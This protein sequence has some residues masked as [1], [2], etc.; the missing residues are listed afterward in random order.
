MQALE[1]PWGPNIE[2]G[3]GAE[4][5]RSEIRAQCQVGD[6]LAGLATRKGE[7]M[8]E[9]EGNLCV[10]RRYVLEVVLWSD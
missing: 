8:M 2:V 4:M 10:S 9:G 1:H 6:D 3:V 5:V 7:F